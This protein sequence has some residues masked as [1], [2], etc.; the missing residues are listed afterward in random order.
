MKKFAIFSIILSITINCSKHLD[1]KE[2][3]IK[4]SKDSYDFNDVKVINNLGTYT[5]KL[6]KSKI[7]FDKKH[8]IKTPLQYNNKTDE[9]NFNNIY[10]IEDSL[11]NIFYFRFGWI[12]YSDDK[13]ILSNVK[14]INKK[15]QYSSDYTSFEFSVVSI[16]YRQIGD[17]TVCTIGDSQTWWNIA[18]NL[19]RL[20]NDNMS[21]LVFIGSNT[22]IYGYGHEGEGGN[23]TKQVLNRI[24]N[25]KKADYYTL[26]IG[27]NDW[28]GDVSN[29]YRNILKIIE[30]IYVI[31]PKATVIY[32]T[33]LP[34]SNEERNEFNK[35]LSTRLLKEFNKT[36]KVKILDLG[37]IMKENDN[38]EKQFLLKDGLHQ[39]MNGVKFM[40]KLISKKIELLNNEKNSILNIN[41]EK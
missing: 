19:R 4:P 1:K 21:E 2:P 32:L 40:A 34:T 8:K 29:S 28:K 30:Q 7:Y 39:N 20:I 16:P 24:K 11:N 14:W 3:S 5:V 38:W 12:S 23:G 18:Q 37:K 22:D 25:I 27:T 13:T 17:I 33:P 35:E 9:F 26:L 41:R 6:S 31:N 10:K 36:Q 15:P